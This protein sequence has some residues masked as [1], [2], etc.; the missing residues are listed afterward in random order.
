MLTDRDGHRLPGWIAAVEADTLPKLTSFARHLRQ[1]LDAVTAGLTLPY[2]SG[3]VEGAVN[4]NDQAP[5]VRSSELRSPPKAGTAQSL[6]DG[7]PSRSQ[8]QRQNP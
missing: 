6:T 4:R 7:Q 5:D 1:D 2:S 3:A 8:D